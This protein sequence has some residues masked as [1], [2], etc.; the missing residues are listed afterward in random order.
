MGTVL[1]FLQRVIQ[2]VDK[3]GVADRDVGP[4]DLSM[5]AQRTFGVGVEVVLSG[6]LPA[7]SGGQL[8]V[9]V[10]SSGRGQPTHANT[11]VK[12]YV[13]GDLVHDAAD[14]DLTRVNA[15]LT[16]GQT[17]YVGQIAAG[18]QT[19]EVKVKYSS[20]VF[21]CGFNARVIGAS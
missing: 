7:H 11:Y 15:E 3:G 1:S 20:L 4:T 19:I 2:V 16:Y 14:D 10:F 21:F 13:D 9:S 18:N 6:A 12:I 17:M 8:V 5:T